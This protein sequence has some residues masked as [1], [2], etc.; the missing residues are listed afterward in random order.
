[1]ESVAVDRRKEVWS[2]WEFVPD[3]Q[4]DEIYQKYS[5]EEQ[6]MCACADLYV[7]INPRSSWTDVCRGLYLMNEMTA[8]RE[9]KTFIPRTGK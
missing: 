8:A 4:L 9:A 2:Y 7:N 1:M 6:R 3:K 5:T